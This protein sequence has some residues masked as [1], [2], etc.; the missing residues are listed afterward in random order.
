MEMPMCGLVGLYHKHGGA[1]QDAVAARNLSS[2]SQKMLDTLRK[3]G[4]DECSSVEM[5]SAFL[6]HTRLSII[7]L[8]TGSQ[9]IYN[10]DKTI[11]VLLNGEIYNFHELRAGLEARGH[12]FQSTSDT[13]VIVHLYEECGD[14]VF[15]KLNGMFAIVIYDTRA[16]VFLAAR[17]RAGEKPLVYWE[18]PE[19][20]AV[21]SEIKTLLEI[22]GVSRELDSNALALYLNSMYV[23]APTSIFADIRKLPPGHFIKSGNG[24]VSVHQYWDPRQDI[25]WG[26]REKDIL[27]QFLGIFEDSV[28]IRTYSDVPLGVFLSGGI[29]SSAVTAFMARNCSQPVKTFSVGFSQENDE[30]PFARMVA[31]RYQTEHTE[32][33]INDRVDS[34]VE[35]VIGYFDEPFGDS[36]AIPTYL[37]SREAR[38][39]V[40]VILTGDGGDELFAGYDAYLNQKYQTGSR[41]A[42]KLYK[43]INQLSSRL[44]GHGLLEKA[45]PRQI[46][47]TRAFQHWHRVR[48]IFLDHEATDM[49]P[50]RN[51]SSQEFF[52]HNQWLQLQGN[53]ALTTS[54][55]FDMNFYLP[56]DLLKKVDMASMM[57][58]IECRAPFLDHRLIE[59][60]LRVPP[61]LKVKDDCL[62]YLLKQ[63][64]VDFLPPEILYR[65]KLGFGAPVESWLKNYLKDMTLSLLA[66]GNAKIENL[67]SPEVIQRTLNTF[68]GADSY[69]DFRVPHKVWL[70]LVLEIWMRKYL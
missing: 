19:L 23:P 34:V 30:R 47:N 41:V 25:Q 56:D 37:I 60:S 21:A 59:F 53:D 43:T 8:Q 24:K 15:S 50:R 58:G 20:L 54:F 69:K 62:K 39:H 38:K 31:E 55:A 51:S 29:D 3:R 7:D 16:N 46:N 52:K 66:P 48:S 18:S 1:V 33:F 44:F 27:E 49:V 6:G 57:C 45:Y 26:W 63:S 36:S 22:P 17:D 35:E 11:A 12:R 68:Y 70:L 67:I 5:R 4:P 64:L 40:K 9:P 28:K 2:F 13:E 42:S 14:D 61:N 10:E 65:S 32:I